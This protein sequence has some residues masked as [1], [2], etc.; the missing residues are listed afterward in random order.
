MIRIGPAGTGGLG[1]L[2]GVE[3][4]NRLGLRAMEVEF[5]Y[6]VNM[7]NETA[8]KVGELAKKLN[9][10]LSVHAPYFCNLASKEK[11]KIYATIKRVVDSCERAHHL[12][13][14]HVVFHAGFYQGRNPEEVYGMI[15][16]GMIKIMDAIKENKLKTIIAPETTGKASQFGNIDELLKMRKET[17]CGICIDF[18]HLLAREGKRDYN[19]IFRKIKK[20]KHIHSHF[21]GIEYTEKGERRHLMTET[22]DIKE[23][24]QHILKHKADIT[25]INESPDPVGDSIKTKKIFE[26]LGAKV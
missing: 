9:V 1:G 14:T 15:K 22:K 17:G 8:K 23:L 16:Q 5:T 24:A 26:Q 4:V 6:G 20:L 25:I 10:A 19:E 21:S 3:E 12:G 18:A 7:S 13:A 11:P 2:K